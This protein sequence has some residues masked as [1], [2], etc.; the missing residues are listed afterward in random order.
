MR[1]IVFICSTLFVFSCHK[2]DT[3]LTI[4]IDYLEQSL[5]KDLVEITSPDLKL[6]V[7]ANDYLPAGWEYQEDEYFF[8]I[9]NRPLPEGWISIYFKQ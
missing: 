9:D 3:P 8:E 1:L 4:D 7:L 6:S 5:E 2:P